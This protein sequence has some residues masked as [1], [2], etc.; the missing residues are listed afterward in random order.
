MGK[1]GY[2]IFTITAKNR[3]S[4]NADLLP[5][6]NLDGLGRHLLNLVAADALRMQKNPIPEKD[7]EAENAYRI[8]GQQGRGAWILLNASVG[9]YGTPGNLVDIDNGSDQPYRDRQATM[10]D[11]RAFL[12][13]PKGSYTGVLICERRGLRSL[14]SQI[15]KG[16]L[17]PIGENLGITF[18]V[19]THVDAGAWKEYLDNA[20]AY[21][22]TAV[23]RS[24][25]REDLEPGRHKRSEIRL[26]ATGNVALRAARQMRSV[27]KALTE[28]KP[29]RH[30]EIAEL[31]PKAKDFKRDR[32]EVVVGDEESTRT[33]VIEE[34]QLPQ[35]I[36]PLDNFLSTDTLLEEWIPE[37]GRILSEVENRVPKDWAKQTRP[38]T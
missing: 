12:A 17:K 33:V 1:I 6:D 38:S 5:L 7:E 18:H 24:T 4:R 34:G 19:A 14:K 32:Y 22:V 28:K 31:Q 20:T 3:R 16:L 23:Y 21:S 36:Y 27:F 30:I 25:L 37:A 29:V 15:E 9:P 11:L 26:T 10:V 13:I 35:W 2:V 8:N